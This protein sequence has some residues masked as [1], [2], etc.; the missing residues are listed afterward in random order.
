[1]EIVLYSDWDVQM[2][3]VLGLAVTPAITLS[4]R[5]HVSLMAATEQDLHMSFQAI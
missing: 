5:G 2:H 4:L 3:A 1:M